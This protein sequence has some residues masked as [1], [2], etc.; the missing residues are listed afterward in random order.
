LGAKFQCGRRLI[1]QHPAGEHGMVNGKFGHAKADDPDRWYRVDLRRSRVVGR[2][3][4]AFGQ[5]RS[6]DTGKWIVNNRGCANLHP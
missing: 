2:W 4:A 1:V 6:V 3:P 5:K